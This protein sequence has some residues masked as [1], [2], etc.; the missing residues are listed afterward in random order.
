MA[1]HLAAI[2]GVFVL[3]HSPTRLLRVEGALNLR[4]IGGY[5]AAA[6][7]ATRWRTVLRSGSL[8]A[9]SRSGHDALVALQLRSIIDLRTAAEIASEPN[10]LAGHPEISYTN[11]AL[12]NALRPHAQPLPGL[13]EFYGRM[14]DEGRDAIGAV[15][16]RLATPGALPALIHCTAGKDRTGLIV[17][18]LL[19]LVGVPNH[20]IAADFALSEPALAAAPAF[21]HHRQ[22]LQATGLGHL[23]CAPPELI[24]ESLSSIEERH[25]SVVDYLHT[26]GL[27]TPTLMRLRTALLTEAASDR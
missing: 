2:E 26:C 14:L 7:R 24:D 9:L 13:P 16:E 17:A 25:G 8:H 5:A 27:T 11:V 19:S 12:V 23:L 1:C 18:L 22:R 15:F 4:D 10:P 6:G 20:V 21:A 3:A